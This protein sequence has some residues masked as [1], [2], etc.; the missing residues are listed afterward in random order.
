ME[1]S[2]YD[3][4]FGSNLRF[5]DRL[6]FEFTGLGGDKKKL[7]FLLKTNNPPVYFSDGSLSLWAV[8]ALQLEGSKI[9]IFTVNCLLQISRHK[10][11][12]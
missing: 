6:V 3:F 4:G 12:V 10:C 5:G 9:S 2:T 1:C 8:A 11:N 7:F